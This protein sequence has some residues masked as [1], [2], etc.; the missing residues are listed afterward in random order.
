MLGRPAAL[1]LVGDPAVD[2]AEDLEAAAIGQDRPIPAHEAM[3]PAHT[4]DQLVAGLKVQVVGV[5]END[6]RAVIAHLVGRQ[7]FDGAARADR[8]KHGR[9]DRAV[10]GG[11]QAGAGARVADR[12]IELRS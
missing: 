5:A 4:R 12:G 7:R 11:D 9:L 10:R 6:L 1:D 2:Q 3:Q 8:H